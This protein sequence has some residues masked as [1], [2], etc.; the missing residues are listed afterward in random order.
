MNCKREKAGKK[1][2]KD[3]DYELSPNIF[4]DGYRE[5]KIS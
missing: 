1:F 5:V 3:E 4:G 2:E